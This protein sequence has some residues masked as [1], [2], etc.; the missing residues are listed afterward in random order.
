MK[1]ENHQ[2]AREENNNSN[3]QETDKNMQTE[4]D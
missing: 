1:S 2:T 4:H 3:F